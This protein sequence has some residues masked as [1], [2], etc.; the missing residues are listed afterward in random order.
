MRNFMRIATLLA[1]A[2]ACSSAVA[3]DS[4]STGLTDALDP[5][6]SSQREAYA[7]DLAPFTSSLGWT[8]GILPII[9]SAQE[10]GSGFS[11]NLTS[12]NAISS[13]TITVSESPLS[14]PFQFWTA[15]GAGVSPTGNSTPG[16]ASLPF[17]S[18]FQQAVANSDFGGDS[19]NLNGAVFNFSLN[20]PNRL[21]V[22]RIFAGQNRSV[23]GDSTSGFGGVSIDANGNLY[24]RADGG[25]AV[26]GTPNALPN[27]GNGFSS[28]YRVDLLARTAG[29]NL[30]DDINTFD[31]GTS[32]TRLVT[33]APDAASFLAWAPPNLMPESVIG[34]PGAFVGVN[35]SD[36]LVRGFTGIT[37]QDMS[38]FDTTVDDHRGSTGQ[39][40]GVL[41]TPGGDAGGAI[42]TYG[43]LTQPPMGDTIGL[44]IF[45]LDA[46]LNVV[47]N[48][49]QLL[50]PAVTDNDDGFVLNTTI[51]EFNAYRS[52]TIFRGGVGMVA[53]GQDLE[54][55]ALAASTFY[56]N[57]IAADPFTHIP[58]ARW[59]PDAPGTVEWT[60]AA[61]V[62]V[63]TGGT[64]GKPI[65]GASGDVIGQLVGLNLVT[66]GAPTGP[67][68]SVPAF[69]SAGNVWFIGA[70]EF[71]GA[72]GVSDFD[73]ALLRGVYDA[74]SFSYRL[75]R[76]VELGNVFF[77]QNS[78]T[79]YQVQFIGPIADSNSVGSGGN[80]S[81][82]VNQAPFA[83]GTGFTPSGTADS[84][85]LGGVV[86]NAEI[87]YNTNT[88]DDIQNPDGTTTFV[89]DEDN[90]DQ[91]YQTLLYIAHYQCPADLDNNGAL[92]FF[93]VLAYLGLF[94]AQDP[95]ADLAAPIGA[96]DFF[97]VLDFL[98]RF[99][100]G[101]AAPGADPFAFGG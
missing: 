5:L 78:D 73:S 21:F 38:H 17:G 72:D 14:G 8:W 101:C 87:V 57:G 77:G 54:G 16:S 43:Q 6:G 15:P 9:K 24:F 67:S 65:Y 84:R 20:R 34:A 28:W 82:S 4:T 53:M 75:E 95:A 22:E 29:I 40:N 88:D 51:G 63:F 48:Q 59:N 64:T 33:N 90:G 10:P 45:T 39:Y 76:V 52:Q 97:D 7:N 46:N 35:D 61:Y 91:S 60:L 11:S 50:P 25:D 26:A 86:L 74:D 89:F 70:V 55:N 23:I 36:E 85:N 92:D 93:D 71:F 30:I 68:A 2:G 83:N 66:G 47:E 12:A 100:D 94:D 49:A 3:Q 19:E 58:V 32:T 18:L 42:Q 13:D 96:F 1:T 37:A 41:L 79:P 31:G 80:F 99:D 98:G 69:D 27:T 62:D 81:N 56:E 44:N